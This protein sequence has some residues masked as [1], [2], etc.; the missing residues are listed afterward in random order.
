MFTILLES[1]NRKNKICFTFVCLIEK[2]NIQPH[3]KKSNYY[4]YTRLL[5]IYKI[6]MNNV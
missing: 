1:N 4:T 5:Y 6:K 3:N 2:Q